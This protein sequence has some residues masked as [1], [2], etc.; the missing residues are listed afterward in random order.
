[1][2]NVED[3]SREEEIVEK[4]DMKAMISAEVFVCGNE[5][6]EKSLSTIMDETR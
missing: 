1:M 2:E 4:A 6:K 3:G 5:V